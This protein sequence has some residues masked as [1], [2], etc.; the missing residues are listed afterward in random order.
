MILVVCLLV[1]AV[2]GYFWYAMGQPLYKPGTVA[3]EKN[4]RGPLTPPPQS[5]DEHYWTV[6]EDIEIYHLSSGQGRNVLVV[7][8]GPGG[9]HG[10]S[11]PGLDLLTDAY[12]F[13]YYDQRG[14]GRSTRPSGRAC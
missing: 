7:H 1:A 8:G 12:R 13:H 4:L 11:W 9:A 6:E 2:A 10:S 3:A 5:G 14:C